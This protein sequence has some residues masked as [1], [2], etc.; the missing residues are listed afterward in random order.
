MSVAELVIAAPGQDLDAQVAEL[1]LGYTR[2]KSPPDARG[3]HGGEDLLI[4][5]G[6]VGCDFTYPPRGAIGLCYHV[7]QYSTS[8]RDAWDLIPEL[9]RR[10][11][12]VAMQQVRDS[13]ENAVQGLVWAVQVLDTRTEG[14]ARDGRAT[15]A[16]FPAALCRAAVKAARLR[17]EGLEAVR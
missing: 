15:D 12:R 2:T 10:G 6:G 7:R 4:P 16:S 5:P 1:V 17:Q 9:N 8:D 11:Y 3:E 13:P 14:P